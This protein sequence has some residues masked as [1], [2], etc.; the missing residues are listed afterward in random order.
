M[1]NV[2]SDYQTYLVC[3][4]LIRKSARKVFRSQKN[5]FVTRFEVKNLVHEHNITVFQAILTLTIG[6]GRWEQCRNRF[7]DCDDSYTDTNGFIWEVGKITA[8]TEEEK[9][10]IRNQIL[11]S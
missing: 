1:I 6:G 2:D 8:V 3:I 4:S 9:C 10:K 5:F 7:K 11:I